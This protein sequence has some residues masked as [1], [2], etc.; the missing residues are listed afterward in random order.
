VSIIR[1]E[2]NAGNETIIVLKSRQHVLHG[3]LSLQYK[4]C[5]EAAYLA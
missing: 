5:D 2:L 1:M 4:A 3:I